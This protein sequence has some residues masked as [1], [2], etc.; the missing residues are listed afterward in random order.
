MHRNI[1]PDNIIII[2]NYKV[3]LQDFYFSQYITNANI[4]EKSSYSAVGT[5]LYASMEILNHRNY[6]A[7]CDLWGLGVVLI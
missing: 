5:P 3:K 6:S 4:Y 7:K 1:R 2:E